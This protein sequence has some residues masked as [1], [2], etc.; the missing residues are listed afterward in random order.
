MIIILR[1]QII[2]IMKLMNHLKKFKDPRK[3]EK[4]K[5]N[6][7]M[8]N[9]VIK[10]KNI[11]KIIYNNNLFK[12][13]MI[14]YRILIHINLKIYNNFKMIILPKNLFNKLNNK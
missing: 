6:L 12:I 10:N 3:K 7:L 2:N 5:I 8:K 4:K 11:Q 9:L 13:I 14:S 1:I